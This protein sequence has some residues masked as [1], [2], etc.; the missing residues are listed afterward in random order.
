[1]ALFHLNRISFE[2]DLQDFDATQRSA[3]FSM[4]KNGPSLKWSLDS[5]RT[6]VGDWLAGHPGPQ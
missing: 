3:R 2:S 1:V 6:G 4:I 5:R